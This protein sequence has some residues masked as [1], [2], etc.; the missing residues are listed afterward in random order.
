MSEA[1]P[2]KGFRT[3]RMMFI[4]ITLVIGVVGV[5]AVAEFYSQGQPVIGPGPPNP[6]GQVYQ[7][8][9][10]GEFVR[11]K[12]F[13]LTE[14]G[15]TCS[16]S[17]GSCTMT[18]I[19]NGTSRDVVTTGCSMMLPIFVNGTGSGQS[20]MVMSVE[21]INGG[22]AASGVKP[23]AQ[24]NA[25]CWFPTN[26]YMIDATVDQ[27]VNGC[28][29][30]AQSGNLTNTVELCWTFGNWSTVPGTNP[31]LN[32]PA[33][34]GNVRVSFSSL[35]VTVGMV[36]ITNAN[37]FGIWVT[38]TNGSSTVGPLGISVTGPYVGQW[39]AIPQK[40]TVPATSTTTLNLPGAPSTGE[41]VSY[42]LSFLPT[43]ETITYT[44]PCSMTVSGTYPFTSGQ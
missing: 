13:F 5:A 34:L 21:S 38:S 26:K 17:N 8:Q 11:C 44:Q 32:C 42:S 22:P 2:S 29:T 9:F 43:N 28:F 31:S 20:V 1:V 40:M 35:N 36:T 16:L 3:R 23:A 24:S 10:R 27:G 18:V 6:C 14:S 7:G 39:F 30:F 33:L 15:A 41:Q 19:N 37:P 25:T 12:G 4:V